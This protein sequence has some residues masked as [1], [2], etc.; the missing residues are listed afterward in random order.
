MNEWMYIVHIHTCMHVVGFLSILVLYKWKLVI[1][2][3]GF[4]FVRFWESTRYSQ[5]PW[6]CSA[7]SKVHIFSSEK[8]FSLLLWFVVSSRTAVV[9]GLNVNLEIST[10]SAPPSHSAVISA[11]TVHCRLF[12]NEKV[13]ERTGDTPSYAEAM[14]MKLPRVHSMAA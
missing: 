11:L 9:Q 5:R 4:C 10:P 8:R 3:V 2:W 7:S 1:E 14:K 13:R 12:E 6:R